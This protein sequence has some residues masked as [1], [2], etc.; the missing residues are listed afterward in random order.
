M[1]VSEIVNHFCKNHIEY[2]QDHIEIIEDAHILLG[3]CSSKTHDPVGFISWELETTYRH[4]RKV[5]VTARCCGQYKKEVREDI[6]W[7]DDDDHELVI[8]ERTPDFADHFLSHKCTMDWLE[9]LG[10]IRIERMTLETH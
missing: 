1:R 8:P 2:R 5:V 7:M 9:E 6:I 4:A 3:P 10:L